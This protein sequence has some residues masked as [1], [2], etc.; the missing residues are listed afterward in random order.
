MGPCNEVRDAVVATT[1]RAGVRALLALRDVPSAPNV[2]AALPGKGRGPLP[3]NSLSEVPSDR[4][5]LWTRRA[6]VAGRLRAFV[7][8][9]VARCPKAR[10]QLNDGYNTEGLG[11]LV[12]RCPWGSAKKR[13]H[14]MCAWRGG[15]NATGRYIE[16]T[17]SAPLVKHD[18]AFLVANIGYRCFRRRHRMRAHDCSRINPV[19]GCT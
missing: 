8:P 9:L 12:A 2:H 6:D 3:C 15:K 5:K 17:P 13:L 11:M 19:F 14:G 10:C 4:C 1:V 16:A 7:V 18:R